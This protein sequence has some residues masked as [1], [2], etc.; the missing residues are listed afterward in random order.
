M[1]CKRVGSQVSTKVC[2]C[3]TSVGTRARLAHESRKR[4]NRLGLALR[5]LEEETHKR[6]LEFEGE[7]QRS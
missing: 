2:A 6:W 4:R 7:S 1:C 5:S 3:P